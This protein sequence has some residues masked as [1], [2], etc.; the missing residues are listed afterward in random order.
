MMDGVVGIVRVSEGQLET[1]EE[2]ML[3]VEELLIDVVRV[4]VEFVERIQ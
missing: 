2:V 1:F 4:F 3:K